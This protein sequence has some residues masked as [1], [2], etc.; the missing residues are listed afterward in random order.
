[1]KHGASRNFGGRAHKRPIKAQVSHSYTAPDRLGLCLPGVILGDNQGAGA[2]PLGTLSVEHSHGP[3]A[4]PCRSTHPAFQQCAPFSFLKEGSQKI[5]QKRH[6]MFTLR[7]KP[8][9]ELFLTMK[10]A[11][12]MDLSLQVYLSHR[13]TWTPRLCVQ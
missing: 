8:E 5:H 3:G 12:T 2:K 1:M 11:C 9:A 13:L 10:Y 6:L 4:P 7:L